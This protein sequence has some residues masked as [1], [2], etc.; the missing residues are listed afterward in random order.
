MSCSA[1]S[2]GGRRRSRRTSRSRKMRGGMG[3]GFGGTIGTAGPVWDSSW[4]G[5]VTKAGAPVYDTMN[6]QRGSSRRRKSRRGG[7][8]DDLVDVIASKTEMSEDV[9]R[10][11]GAIDTMTRKEA[12]EKGY[13]ILGPAKKGSSRRRKGKKSSRRRR[14]MRGGAGWQSVSGVGAAFKGEGSRGLAD[15][16][17]YASKVPPAGG[18]TQ[19]PDGAYHV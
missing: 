11:A 19:N 6:P 12:E 18:P 3:Y 9:A 15:F 14:T 5:E 7:A 10:A 16:T 13:K 17:G 4:G 1:P 8:E 2:T